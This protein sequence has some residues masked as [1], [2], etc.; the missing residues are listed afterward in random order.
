L[1]FFLPTITTTKPKIY[2]NIWNDGL[3]FWVSNPQNQKY[4]VGSPSTLVAAKKGRDRSDLKLHSP[5]Q[6]K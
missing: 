1:N 6:F 2:E 4:N 5:I 3:Y